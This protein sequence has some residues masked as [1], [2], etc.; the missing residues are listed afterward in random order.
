[1]I[2][3]SII[4]TCYNREKFISRCIRSALHQKNVSRSSYEIIVVDDCSKDSSLI[5][6][7][8][9]DSLIKIVKNKKNIGLSKSRNK[10]IKL[11]KGKYITMLDSDDF[12]AENYLFV[13]GQ[14]LDLN[15]SWHAVCC[16]YYKVDI[17]GKK[18][19]RYY[20][21]KN[22]L[23]CGILYRREN[24]FKAGLYNP[25][26]RYGEDTDLEKKFKAKF[27]FKHINL[28]L[29]RYTMHKNNLSK[30]YK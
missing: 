19:G 14:F 17:N 26:L 20:F 22:P 21:E 24:L 25:N 8:E 9:F 10:A 29:Y 15:Q 11:S 30:K 2:D 16:D 4:I 13:M 18:I 1:M 28:P 12:I 5:K 3:F 23:A 6:I 7:H 27:I